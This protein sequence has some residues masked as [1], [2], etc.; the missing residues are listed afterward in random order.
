MISMIVS[1]VVFW[2]VCSA[3]SDDVTSL[4]GLWQ[5]EL[6]SQMYIEVTKDLVVQGWYNSSVGDANGTYPL[7]GLVS[8]SA[9]SQRTIAFNVLWVNGI[10]DSPAITS[11]NG[12]Y[13]PTL[14]NIVAAWTLLVVPRTWHSASFGADTF[15][16]VQQ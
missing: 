9:K 15:V 13:D 1:I 10:V 16:K 7:I 14:N 3:T 2:T 5:N 12:Y 11:W 4:N 8:P 6:Q